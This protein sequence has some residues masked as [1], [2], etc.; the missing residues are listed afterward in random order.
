V[1]ICDE[2]GFGSYG[3]KCII[4]GHTAVSD[5]YYCAACTQMEKN[6]DGCPKIINLGSTR[7]DAFYEKKK[8]QMRD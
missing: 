1:K 5:A 2:C 6:R 8:G 3:N 4:C 7:T